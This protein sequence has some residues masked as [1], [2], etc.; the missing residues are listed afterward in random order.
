MR[1]IISLIHISLDGFAAGPSGEMDFIKINESVFEFVDGYIKGVD[2]AF[3]GPKTFDMMESYWPGVLKDPKAAGHAAR[4]A[5][6]YAHV[7][8]VVF[9]R[10]R[11]SLENPN[12][13]LITSDVA[14]AVKT[15]KSKQGQD[16]MIFGSPGL[17]NSL[18][19]LGLIDEFVMTINP[20]VLGSGTALFSGLDARIGLDLVTAKH[21]DCGS[22]GC[23]YKRAAV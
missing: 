12:A 7:E 15:L 22:I 1:K 11:K 4:H 18:A 21:F 13:K 3:Y 20:M 10:T 19:K 9:S 8:K 6:W 5:K 2:T 16:I 23:H 14:A 17:A